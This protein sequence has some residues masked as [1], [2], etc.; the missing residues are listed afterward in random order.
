MSIPLPPLH[1]LIGRIATAGGDYPGYIVDQLRARD[2][3]VAKLVLEA[4]AKVCHDLAAANGKL[5]PVCTSAQLGCAEAI[6]LL[7]FKHE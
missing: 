7:E 1:E 5:F 4:A 3:E 2:L 6:V